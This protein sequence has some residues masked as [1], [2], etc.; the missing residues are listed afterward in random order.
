M[1]RLA[2]VV[3]LILSVVPVFSEDTLQDRIA[4]TDM[5]SADGVFALAMWC[6]D[7]RL[8]T[9]C[10]KYLNM[11]LKIDTDNPDAREALGFVR[12]GERWVP[13]Q[14]APA[15]PPPGAAGTAAATFRS[16]PGPTAEQI[17]WDLSLPADPDPSDLFINKYIDRLPTVDKEGDDMDVSV[18]T[19]IDEKYWKSAC[20][21]LCAA[22]LRD[23]FT[24]LYGASTM[25][26]ELGH[27]NRLE[28]ARP[29]LPFLMKAGTRITTTADLD[30]F[31]W[32]LAVFKDKRCVP[33]LIELMQGPDPD[34]AKSAVSAVSSITHLPAA[35][36]DA[37]KAQLWWNDNCNLSEQ[38]SLHAQLNASDD[39]EVL[40]AV[41]SLYVLR[42]TALM[43]ALIRLLGSQIPAVRTGA[44]DLFGKITG[45]EWGFDPLGPDA[46]R[47]KIVAHITG[48]WKESSETFA[49][50]E[51]PGAAP[52]AT[53]EASQWVSNLD[54]TTGTTALEAENSLRSRGMDSVPALLTGLGAPS[55]LTRLR[56]YE[57]LKAVTGQA[58][59]YDAHDTDEN[60][61]KAIQAWQDWYKSHL[62]GTDK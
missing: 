58:I 13:K 14:F 1:L 3:T 51:A 28:E 33:R 54:A 29:L 45:N 38:D 19:C 4:A 15:Q 59:D 26:M 21:R 49:F 12:V 41:R 17:R 20:P 7:H 16:A 25:V 62:A 31:C 46:D 11:V 42:D 47:A 8:P 61:A 52:V 27:K 37:A 6:R 2:L 53:D 43:P 50:P 24:D 5:T 48:W 36:L 40:E 44:I 34:V 18:A 55:T 60:R 10:N 35:S 39:S 22:L 56:C 30:A 32:A 57:L 23:D 9:T